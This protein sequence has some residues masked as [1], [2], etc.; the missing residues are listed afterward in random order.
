MLWIYR[1]VALWPPHALSTISGKGLDRTGQFLQESECRQRRGKTEERQFRKDS[2]IREAK[3]AAEIE[4]G[5]DQCS[6]GVSMVSCQCNGRDM[7]RN[8]DCI[9]KASQLLEWWRGKDLG[10]AGRG[11]YLA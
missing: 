8:L 4:C 10:K 7:G 9:E 5:T 11:L 3:Q 2:N 1:H 6:K